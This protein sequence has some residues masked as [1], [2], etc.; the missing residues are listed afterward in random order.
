MFESRKDI[1]DLQFE[2]NFMYQR[3][4]KFDEADYE[5]RLKRAVSL[6][7]DELVERELKGLSLSVLLSIEKEIPVTALVT[8]G[9]QSIYDISHLSEFVLQ[10]I[11]GVVPDYAR[12]IIISISKIMVD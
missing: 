6:V 10:K 12:V 7:L 11:K 3:L 9:Y 2:L 4:G 1:K 8:S 5:E